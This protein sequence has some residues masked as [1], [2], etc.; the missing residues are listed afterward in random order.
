MDLSPEQESDIIYSFLKVGVPPSAVASALGMNV[1]LVKAAQSQIRVE[2]YGTDEISEA[3]THLIWVGYETCLHEIQY[4]PPAS[5]WRAMQMVLARSIGIAGKSSPETSEKIRAAIEELT[6]GIAP[7]I[8][9]ADSIY[10][11]V[12]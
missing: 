1:D 3:M 11:P 5:K 8:Q 10:T 6:A 9:L 7:E 12:E 2:K 4:G